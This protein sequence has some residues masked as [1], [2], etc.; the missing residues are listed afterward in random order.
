VNASTDHAVAVTA[1]EQAELVAAPRPAEPLGP[2]QVEGRTLA[3]L[4]SPGTEL[5]SAY[6]GERFP[7]TPGYAA[8]FQV[9]AVGCEVGDAAVGDRL[10][11]M[12]PHRSWQ[13]VRA[14]E[15][16]A[17]PAGL[18]AEAA[19]FARMMCVSMSTLTTTTA[20]PPEP[21][22]VTGLGLVGHLA[23][24]VFARGGYQ[25]T[26]VEPLEPRRELASAAGIER[27]LPS[28]PLDDERLAGTMALVV[29][30][31]GHEQ[32]ALDG[33]RMV[34]K[35]GEV[36]LVGVPWRRHTDLSAHELLDAIFH[37]YAVVRSGWEWEVPRQPT[38]FRA[39]SLVGQFAAALRWLAEGHVRV[40]GLAATRPPREAQ[41]AYQHLLQRR[42]GALSVVFDWTACP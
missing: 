24:Q 29:E 33:C 8:V 17:V 27:V 5:A 13:R 31:S 3:T 37:K 6:L 12:G 41:Q 30:C 28:V 2:H 18:A 38:D 36:V 19:V 4:V 22:L 21:V 20:R 34:R 32:A 23:A 11:C 9:E 7:R 35:R 42:G 26:A 16:V 1:R 39:G 14:A 15:A 10:F 25:V 40:E